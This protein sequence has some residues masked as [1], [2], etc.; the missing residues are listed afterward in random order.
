MRW[1]LRSMTC[2]KR[3]ASLF[4]VCRCHQTDISSTAK[5]QQA[6]A[7]PGICSAKC[8]QGIG[9]AEEG[10][11]EAMTCLILYLIFNILFTVYVHL[12]PYSGV[13]YI[14]LVFLIFVPSFSFSLF[15]CIIP[16]RVVLNCCLCLLSSWILW[17]NM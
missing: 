7:G 3:S 2:L 10:L 6:F 15:R 5:R 11:C 4:G 1:T 8:T 13:T 16:T 14:L 9:A 12:F 17:M